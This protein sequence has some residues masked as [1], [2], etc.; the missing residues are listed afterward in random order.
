MA[1]T[2]FIR[3]NTSSFEDDD[4]ETGDCEKS[5]DDENKKEGGVSS[6]GADTCVQVQLPKKL[7][8]HRRFKGKKKTIYKLLR[9]WFNLHNQILCQLSIR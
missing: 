8:K 6:S 5:K 7:Q 1:K 3:T 4:E 2:P 9:K